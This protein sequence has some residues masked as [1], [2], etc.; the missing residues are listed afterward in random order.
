MK[1]T[2]IE[3]KL[4]INEDNLQKLLKLELMQNSIQQDSKTVRRLRT[5]YY[6]T[7]DMLLKAKGIAY[8]VRDKGDG[9]FEATVKMSYKKSSGLSERMELNIP[10]TENKA[11]L[12]GFKELGLP[13]DLADIV[14]NG[15]ECLFT[16]DVERISY[17]LQYKNTL[18]ELAI[19]KGFVI[20]DDKKDIIDE[21]EFEIKEGETSELI[22]FVSSLGNVIPMQ[23]E[24]MSKYAKGLRLRGIPT[25]P[26]A[27]SLVPEDARI[28]L[29]RLQK[30]LC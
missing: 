13:Y 16:V 19:D 21:I 28:S 25:N 27:E 12:T 22:E 1:N 4:L 29:E 3:L 14:P 17:L 18:I 9:T 24:P 23:T 5:S 8:R 2:E 15:V 7:N 30:Q 26:P 6:D 20:A 10:L 11:M